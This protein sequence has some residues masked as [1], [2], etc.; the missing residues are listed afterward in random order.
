[1]GNLS[2]QTRS[3][4]VP[5]FIL[6]DLNCA[7]EDMGFPRWPGAL[8]GRLVLPGDADVAST[9]A[10]G[11]TIDYAIF[12]ESARPYV[13][14]PEVVRHV[15]W[16]PHLGLRLTIAA[17]PGAVQIRVPKMARNYP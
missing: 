6:A 7:P 5:W 15:P 14:G 4:G 8:E 17:R 13:R 9:S 11:R 12:P 10:R 16:G 2:R 3:P 1:M